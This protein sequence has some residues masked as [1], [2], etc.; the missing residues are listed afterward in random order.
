MD[1]VDFGCSPANQ[2]VT[3][4]VSETP[5]TVTNGQFPVPTGAGLGVEV[6]EGMVR[7]LAG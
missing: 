3:Q 6:D 7:L 1:R 5:I 2:D 4:D